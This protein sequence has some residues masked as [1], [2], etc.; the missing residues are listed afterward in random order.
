MTTGD[1]T[2]ILS[3]GL[4][5]LTGLMLF[6]FFFVPFIVDLFEWAFNIGGRRRP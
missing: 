4:F 1:A 6:W 2:A 3:A 5:A